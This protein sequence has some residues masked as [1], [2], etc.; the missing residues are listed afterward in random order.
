[1]KFLPAIFYLLLI[2]TFF[3]SQTNQ[4]PAMVFLDEPTSGLDSFSAIQVCKVLKKVANAGASVLFTIH[5]PSSEIFNSFDHLILL[6]KGR[7]MYQGS[8]QNV[9]E[10][11]A[12]GGHPCPVVYNPADWVISVAQRYP[13]EELE[14]CGFYRN[15]DRQPIEAAIPQKGQNFLGQTITK[16]RF[17]RKYEEKSSTLWTQIKLLF[18]RELIHMYR[19]PLPL[20][21]RFGFTAILSSLIGMIFWKVGEASPADSFNLTS[22]FGALMIL[23]MLALLGTAQP[24]LLF[25][26]EERPIF[27]REYSTDHYSVL[28]YFVSRLFI[29]A[30]NTGIQIV[31]MVVLIYYM[32]SFQG[33]ILI[34]LS[35]TY[36]LAMSGTAMAVM[37]G[38]ISGGNAKFAQQLL[39]LLFIPQ[40]LF[41]G[42]FV[43]PALIPK[44]LQWAQYI[45]VLTYA[46]RMLVVTEFYNCSDNVTENRQCERLVENVRAD[47]DDTSFYWIMLV[48]YFIVFRLLALALLQKSATKFY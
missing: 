32:V 25:F 13:I 28:S 44:I 21:G 14:I 9:P 12:S 24:A 3:L 19:F 7:V 27:L 38:V 35:T 34:Y 16:R 11:F 48:T 10:F 29:E 45:C 6:N 33:S 42:F 40:L 43:S 15:D 17:T 23:L 30:M 47:P 1:M 8:V 22:Q 36:A 26:P 46:V 31:I 2:D 5:Q 37:L 18:R 41:S 4:K 39:P 20:Y